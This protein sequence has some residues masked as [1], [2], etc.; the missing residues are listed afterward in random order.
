MPLTAWVIGG[1]I[2]HLDAQTLHAAV[3][4]AALPT[5]QNVL[6][7]A[8]RYDRSTIVARDAVLLTTLGSLPVVLAVSLLL[9]PG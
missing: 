7:Y 6:V 3:V 8:M 5:A 4:L 9:S 1:P 2:L